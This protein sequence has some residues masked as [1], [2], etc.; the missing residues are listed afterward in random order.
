[1]AGGF[2]VAG[3]FEIAGDSR[4]QGGFERAGFIDR[5]STVL[6]LSLFEM[7]FCQHSDDFFPIDFEL[8]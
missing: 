5:G 7:N 8:M 4:D 2:E 1:M 3:K 6:S